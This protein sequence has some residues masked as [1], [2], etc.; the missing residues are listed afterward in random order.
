MLKHVVVSICHSLL[1]VSSAVAANT[2]VQESAQICAGFTSTSVRATGPIKFNNYS[3]SVEST[4]T[5]IVQESGVLLRKIQN[6]N[7]SDYRKCIIDLTKIMLGLSGPTQKIPVDIFDKVRIGDFGS[8]N[9]NYMRS[10]FGPPLEITSTDDSERK[11][12]TFLSDGYRIEVSFLPRENDRIQGLKVAIDGVGVSRRG[13]LVIDGYW[14]RSRDEVKIGAIL[15][16]TKMKDHFSG[17]DCYP[18]YSGGLPTNSDP[19]YSCSGTASHSLGWVALK[20]HLAAG[21]DTDD[22]YDLFRLKDQYQ[23]GDPDGWPLAPEAVVQLEK[24]TG[25]LDTDSKFEKIG[26]LDQLLR[27]HLENMVVT[28]FQIFND[29]TSGELE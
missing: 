14:N 8:T 26:K 4:G 19:I 1:L 29:L 3:L 20:V 28:G 25:I 9:L 17:V 23:D 15:G 13:E 18:H 10:F 27:A 22:T 6:F 21:D 16:V 2:Y 7:Y 11:Q 24:K 5:L 12:A